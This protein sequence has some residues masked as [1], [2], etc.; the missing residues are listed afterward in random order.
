[1]LSEVP[2]WYYRNCFGYT[3]IVQVFS[4]IYHTIAVTLL[5]PSYE[6][7]FYNN[8]TAEGEG[9]QQKGKGMCK[10]KINITGGQF[11]KKKNFFL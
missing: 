11:Q 5:L 3:S 1:M 9:M 6:M 4:K 8:F 7:S 2:K 10:M